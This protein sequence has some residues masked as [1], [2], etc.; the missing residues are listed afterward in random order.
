MTPLTDSFSREYE[1]FEAA[2]QALF[3]CDTVGYIRS[4]WTT[5]S[6]AAEIANKIL[7]IKDLLCIL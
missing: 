4:L 2:M 7:T 5:P 1:N 6:I 3:A